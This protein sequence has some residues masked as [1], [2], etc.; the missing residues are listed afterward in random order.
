M[1]SNTV[2]IYHEKLITVLS[3]TIC[4][5]R[6]G[7]E[8][9]ICFPVHNGLGFQIVGGNVFN[10]PPDDDDSGRMAPYKS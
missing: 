6:D 1:F 2:E 8:L 10:R 3:H 4:M 7:A 9:T 5:I